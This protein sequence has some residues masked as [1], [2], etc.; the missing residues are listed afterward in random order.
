MRLLS[1]FVFF[2]ALASAVG[3]SPHP[4]PPP[5]F[6]SGG[7]ATSRDFVDSSSAPTVAGISTLMGPP[8]QW[9]YVRGSNFLTGPGNTSLYLVSALSPDSISKPIAAHVYDSNSLGFTVPP[10]N[11]GTCGFPP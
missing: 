10:N 1:Y 4:F 8:G 9:L 2:V 3:A 5:S 6:P 7:G 11:K